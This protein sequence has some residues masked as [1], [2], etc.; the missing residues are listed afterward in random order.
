MERGEKSFYRC[1]SYL[2]SAFMKKIV[3]KND[4]LMKLTDI[5]DIISYI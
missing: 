5:V 4:F 2:V 3:W 1:P